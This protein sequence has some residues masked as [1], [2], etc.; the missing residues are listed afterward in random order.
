MLD[1]PLTG[2]WSVGGHFDTHRF[3][4]QPLRQQGPFYALFWNDK[5]PESA[6]FKEKALEI[7]SE[8]KNVGFLMLVDLPGPGFLIETNRP[9]RPPGLPVANSSGIR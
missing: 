5:S 3:G 4:V 9:R 1:E 2:I 8:Y 7:V 6:E